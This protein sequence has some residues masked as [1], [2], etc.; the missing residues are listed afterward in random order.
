MGT[1]PT[2]VAPRLRRARVED[3]PAIAGLC[4][5]PEELAQLSP[6][7]PWPLSP[8]RVEEWLQA[9]DAG[10]VLEEQGRC[11]AFSELLRGGDSTTQ[12]IAHMV[13]AA[14]SRG[15]GLGRRLLE[16]LKLEATRRRGARR[17]RLSVFADN[18]PARRCYQ[19][20]GFHEIGRE[21]WGGRELLHLQY[22]PGPPPGRI[23]SRPVAAM[24][25]AALVAL[26]SPLLPPSLLGW[27][28]SGPWPSL[29]PV[30]GIGAAAGLA[31]AMLAHP[32]LPR[33]LDGVARLWWG[34]V[35]YGLAWGLL[36]TLL[37][38]AGLLLGG[39]PL[40]GELSA[41]SL[42]VL[43][44]AALVGA[45]KG[46]LLGIALVALRGGTYRPMRRG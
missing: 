2:P 34:S 38:W 46:A 24:L 8:S 27:L 14:D 39:A 11:I 13:V 21:A 25:A 22:A 28:R 44:A 3:A 30:I 9:R 31:A 4:A 1:A 17:L 18:S 45:A 16:Q 19:R 15:R 29:L 20:A 5:S 33:P 32:L 26:A 40:A 7:E 10:W 37:A 6:R 41:T 42:R 23:L 36:A 35:A 43:A 12:W